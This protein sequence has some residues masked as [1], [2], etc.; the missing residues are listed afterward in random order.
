MR[1][2]QVFNPYLPSYEYIP[3]GETHV[4]GNRIYLYGSHDRFRGAGFCLNDYVC[5]SADVN[6][7]TDW[8]YEGVIYKKEQDPR[9][10]NIPE[11][12]P[13]QEL[14]FGIEPESPE[15]LNPRGIHAMWAPDVVQGL[16][17]R[18]YLYYCLDFLPEI[19]VAVCDSPAGKYEF[20]GLVKHEDGTPLGIKEGD[21]LQFDP[22]IFIDDD[23]TIY[24]Y[25]GNAPM[26]KKYAN[27]RQGSQVMRLKE[28][29]VTIKEKPRKLMP[30][31]LE[32]EGS[33]FEGHEFFEA[34]SIRK[35]HGKYYFVYSSVQSHELCYAVSDRPDEG[36]RFGGTLVDIGDIFLDGRTE[37]Q[38][39]NCLGNTHGGIEKAGDQWY[40]FY[41]RQTNR[42][43][44]SRQGC[45]EKIYFDGHGN[46]RQAEVTSCGLNKGPL[47][48]RGFYPARICC[49]LTAVNGAAFSHPESMK[50]DYP[51]L[52]QDIPD[53]D[54]TE[55]LSR[56]DLTEPVQ[57][58]KNMKD[59][60]TAGYKYFD[61]QDVKKVHLQ[62][63]GEARGTVE[64][65]TCLNGK[66]IGTVEVN[67]SNDE[68]QEFHGKM[69]GTDGV[70]GL[71]FTF[72]GIGNFDF[73]GFVLE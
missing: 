67:I 63:R 49:H 40:V 32:S 69:N 22:G 68:W 33:G 27:E 45:A 29:M 46:I 61:L 17:G 42:T 66:V 9:N 50:M 26:Y 52:T 51:Y 57:Y 11:D 34:S 55:E 53:T 44:Y 28:D 15:D 4:F 35:I 70:A 23:K 38:A 41:H 73:R 13:E 16:D 14:M 21:L 19:G 8:K 20:L 37:A 31:I 3:D 30:S 5:Y 64:I 2:K 39:V 12:A 43:N 60:S 58:I 7:L 54:P 48:G 1:N 24:L 10:Q 65:R 25:S 72:R 71:Y 36:Y 59:G 6:D 47:E 62:I 18:Y 56:R